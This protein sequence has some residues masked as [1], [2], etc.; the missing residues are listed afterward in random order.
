MNFTSFKE[1]SEVAINRFADS[2][3]G[4]MSEGKVFDKPMSEYDKP[5]GFLEHLDRR[6]LTPEEREY[7]KDKLGWTDEQLDKCTIDDDGKLHYRTINADKEGTTNE[8]GTRYISK[9]VEINGVEVE[10]VFPEFD[11]TFDATLDE[12]Q[13]KDTDRSQE[14]ECNKQLKEA[15]EDDS[16]LA[17]QFT[18]EQL[19]QIKN[20]DTP[21]GYTWHHNEEPGKMQLVKTDEHQGARHTGGRNMWGGGTANRSATSNQ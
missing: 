11:S 7:Y 3:L 13:R 15:I 14:K 2:P 18:D 9:T 5:L 19:E 17:E 4:K 20:G 10:G 6:A 1:V 8:N 21:D 12:N 16:S